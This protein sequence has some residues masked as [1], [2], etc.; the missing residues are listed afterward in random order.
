MKAG[1]YERLT[2]S[3]PKYSSG[4][5][6]DPT[7]YSSQPRPLSTPLMCLFN[8]TQDVAVCMDLDTRTTSSLWKDKAAVEINVAVLHSYQVH[9]PSCDVRGHRH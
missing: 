2:I 3:V 7:Q 9:R 5:S 1:A 8:L 4:Q 6:T